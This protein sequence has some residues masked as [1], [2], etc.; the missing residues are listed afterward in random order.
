MVEGPK[1][2]LKSERLQCL[3]NQT[4]LQID[5]NSI[6]TRT[7][8]CQLVTRIF[9]VGKELF[10]VLANNSAVRLHFGMNGSERILTK[11][12][13]VAATLP[14]RYNKQLS[15]TLTF[16]TNVVY[17]FDTT[18][19]IK[20]M[21]Y[22]DIAIGRMQ[23]DI[24]S[25]RLDYAEIV[26][27]LRTDPRPIFETIMDQTILPG[28]GNVIKCEGLYESRIHPNAISSQI[29]A[30]RLHSLVRHLKDFS[31]QWYHCTVKSKQVN[32]KIYGQTACS[33]CKTPITLMRSGDSERITYFCSVC[34]AV[35]SSYSERAP[36][37]RDGVLRWLTGAQQ[38]A[39]DIPWAC[40]ACTLLNTS[41]SSAC[42]ACGTKKHVPSAAPPAAPAV[43]TENIFSLPLCKCSRRATLL[44]V[45]KEGAS[46]HRLFFGCGGF[47]KKCDLF[48]WADDK[49]PWCKHRRPAT[50][51][52]VLKP[53]E[54]NGRYFFSCCGEKENS[55][56][57]FEFVAS[58][59]DTV[60]AAVGQKR[61]QAPDDAATRNSK[62]TVTAIGLRVI[63]ADIKIPL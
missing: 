46:K 52:R 26:S 36:V 50:L 17:F 30:K 55:C 19:S 29:D 35:A 41:L 10:I 25:P 60:A 34:Q 8:P 9:N 59:S 33:S 4:L 48:V 11:T 20:Y 58:A 62:E 40:L 15:I 1:V 32:K 49:F 54:N 28:V 5:S 24:M 23:R 14:S 61:K 53:G 63:P 51:R 7:S 39:E 22:L 27:L 45:R 37:A 2:L 18:V 42:E 6:S 3:V 38:S 43:A 16:S 12:D 56:G 13:D 44:R 57:F 31:W 47:G 21:L